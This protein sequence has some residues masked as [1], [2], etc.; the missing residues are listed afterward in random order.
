MAKASK[1]ASWKRREVMIEKYRARRLELRNQ[2]KDM[3]L[4]DEQRE[5]ARIALN[6]LPRLSIETRLSRRCR[7]TGRPRGYLR[8]FAMSRIAFREAANHGLIPGVTK[9]SW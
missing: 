1:I 3:S 4:T 7:V 2:I 6:K 8:K 5:V 9:S